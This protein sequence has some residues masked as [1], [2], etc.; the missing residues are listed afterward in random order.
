MDGRFRSRENRIILFIIVIVLVIMIVSAWT[1]FRRFDKDDKELNLSMFYMDKEEVMGDSRGPSSTSRTR[2][3][4]KNLMIATARWAPCRHML[5]SSLL[6]LRQVDN[7]LEFEYEIP[8]ELFA[9]MERNQ[10]DLKLSQVIRWEQ[11][12]EEFGGWYIHAPIIHLIVDPWRSSQL[13]VMKVGKVGSYQRKVSFGRPLCPDSSL[14]DVRIKL[15]AEA[16]KMAVTSISSEP[17]EI[18]CERKQEK[19]LTLGSGTVTSTSE[20]ETK[21]TDSDPKPNIA[22]VPEAAIPPESGMVVGVSESHGI[23]LVLSRAQ[24][25]GNLEFKFKRSS[26]QGRKSGI[27]NGVDCGHNGCQLQIHLYT[28]RTWDKAE[29]AQ[30][31]ALSIKAREGGNR[32]SKEFPLKSICR[33]KPKFIAIAVRGRGVFGQ[34]LSKGRIVLSAES[35]CVLPQ[36]P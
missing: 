2:K 12:E 22:I 9:C 33:R 10:L 13:E 6:D 7:R 11:R 3:E 23:Q 14:R 32:F 29:T 16:S 30:R 8:A 25:G 1:T 34:L 36:V 20:K 27:D 4:N 31:P 18:R 26:S 35:L 28:G 5:P 21:Y 17:V 15:I 19:E 24:D